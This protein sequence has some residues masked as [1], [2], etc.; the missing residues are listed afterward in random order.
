MATVV[1]D[2]FNRANET[3]LAGNWTGFDGGSS[4]RR[5]NLASNVCVATN[6]TTDDNC[7]Y[8]SANTF[9]NDQFAQAQ[10]TVAGTGGGGQGIGFLL[11]TDGVG[12]SGVATWT[13]YR[14]IADHATSNNI[15]IT[16]VNAGTFTHLATST[17]TWSDNDTWRFEIVGYVLVAKRNETVVLS[18]DDSAS[19]SR[20]VSGRVGITFSSP[21]TSG[22]LDNFSGGELVPGINPSSPT[23]NFKSWFPGT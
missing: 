1:T 21:D 9:W 3:P 10:L 14:F 6:T 22:S 7:A 4:A 8:W 17:L 13:G 12:A 23:W 5:F 11:R 18:Y 2:D 15:D 20:I 19:G 16:R